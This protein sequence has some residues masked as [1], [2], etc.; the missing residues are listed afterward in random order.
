[1]DADVYQERAHTTAI[2]AEKMPALT[3]ADGCVLYAALGLA[4]EV[5]ELCGKLKKGLRKGIPPTQ[6]L[7]DSGFTKEQGDAQWY[8]AE[9]ATL[10]GRPLSEVMDLN[11]DKLSDRQ[12]RGVLRGDG[13]DR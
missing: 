1:M 7:R 10:A 5:G 9:L 8:L 11:L 12:D 3:H 13:D 6:I 2:Y 4:E